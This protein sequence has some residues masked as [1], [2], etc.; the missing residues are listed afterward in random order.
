MKKKAIFDNIIALD[1]G[2]FKYVSRSSFEKTTP[3][4]PA[5]R[6]RNA[7]PFREAAF[8]CFPR[9]PT[10]PVPFPRKKAE[11]CFIAACN[12]AIRAV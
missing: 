9:S 10:W 12:R 2:K 8:P 6:M 5:A 11:I 1:I 4:V 3:P 7:A